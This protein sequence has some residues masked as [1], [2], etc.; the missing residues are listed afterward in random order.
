[1]K[2]KERIEEVLSLLDSVRIKRDDKVYKFSNKKLNKG[3]KFSNYRRLAIIKTDIDSHDVDMNINNKKLEVYYT[4]EIDVR[5]RE[6][7]YIKA[8]AR[9]YQEFKMIP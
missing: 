2:Y 1:M 4:E 7:E 9:I 5:H 8:L 6:K 3:G